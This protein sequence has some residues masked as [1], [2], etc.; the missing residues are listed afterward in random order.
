MV[1]GA[2]TAST[3]GSMI[4]SHGE[5][6][7]AGRDSHLMRKANTALEYFKSVFTTRHSLEQI[8]L[9]FRIRL[10]AQMRKEIGASDK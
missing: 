1:E 4:Y 8:Q 2:F 3:K 5:R 10:S 7:R 6:S 9:F